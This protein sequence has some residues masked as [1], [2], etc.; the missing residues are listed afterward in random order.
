MKSKVLMVSAVFLIVSLVCLGTVSCRQ[1]S[2]EE[3]NGSNDV[4]QPLSE[5][6]YRIEIAAIA[7]EL[8]TIVNG[9]DQMLANP[10]I[11]DSDWIT[12]IILAMEDVTTLCDEACQIV[13]PDSM[14]D[15]HI[16]NLEAIDGLDNAMDMLAEGMDEQD[17]DLVNQATTEM[18]I[19]A[20]ILVEVIDVSE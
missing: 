1:D 16:I 11:E 10:K 4:T 14:A 2:T 8:I 5:D 9:L 15:V 13:P 18:W 20:E 12:T 3:Q 6:E 19:A 17:I 7:V